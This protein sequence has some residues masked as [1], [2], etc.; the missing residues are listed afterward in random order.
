VPR[1]VVIAAVVF[2]SAC[3]NAPDPGRA[4]GGASGP[5]GLAGA[6][7]QSFDVPRTDGRTDSLARHRGQVV[8][9]NLWATWC[10]PCRDEMPVLERFAR[11]YA[12]K[13][14]VLGVDQGESASVAAAYA[15]ERGVTFPILV[16]ERQQYG[17]TYE[18]IGLPTSVIVGRDGHVVR[19][20][21]GAMTLEQMRAA[22]APA[23]ARSAAQR[24][25]GAHM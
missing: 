20:I 25:R 10:P 9:L 3:Y 18:G 14:V 4:G 22:V 21:D 6:P 5:A 19:G 7:A 2:L 16:D 1:F 23:L 15:R 8:L 11:E 24:A 13:V 17:R 12:G